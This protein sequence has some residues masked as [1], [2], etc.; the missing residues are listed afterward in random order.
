VTAHRCLAGA[1]ALCLLLTPAGAPAAPASSFERLEALWSGIQDYSM[2]IDAHEVLGDQSAENELHFAFKRPDHARLD[3]LTGL[4]S[5]S[6]IVWGGG[7]RVTAYMRLFSF[8]KMHGD[9]RQ[10]DL[11]SLRGNGILNPNMG[12]VI[13]CFAA[14]RDQLREH[15]GPEI[16]GKPTDEI[17]LPYRGVECP[18]DPPA[19]RGTVTLDV[20]DVDRQ[21]GLVITRKR[22]EGDAVV[23]RWDMADWRINAGL[24][25]RD[26]R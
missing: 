26:L 6:T 4:R 3:I 19:D 15:D 24:S 22:Y 9:A 5:G 2:T 11:T 14:Y 12:D 17:E 8:F 21:S 23:E 25:D 18:D 13:A 7:D 10:K 20:L 16:A 1:L